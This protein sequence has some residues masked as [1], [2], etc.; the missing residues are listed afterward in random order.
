MQFGEVRLN[1]S[2]KFAQPLIRACV[3]LHRGG[4]LTD[5]LLPLTPSSIQSKVMNL[6]TAAT[7]VSSF[8]RVK[9][10]GPV[11]LAD[12]VTSEDSVYVY[13]I[14]IDNDGFKTEYRLVLGS[15]SVNL[16]IVSRTPL[17]CTVPS[18][19]LAH[20]HFGKVSSTIATGAAARCSQDE[21]A[22]I[23]DFFATLMNARWTRKK[24]KKAFRC[25]KM[26]RAVYAIACIDQAG[27]L[28]MDYMKSVVDI[29]TR[30]EEELSKAV[31]D[32]RHVENRLPRLWSP[33]Y[34]PNVDY[35]VYG[36]SGMTCGAP[37]PYIME[38]VKTYE[39]YYR[40]KHKRLVSSACP[41]YDAQRLWDLPSAVMPF[42][43]TSCI[44]Y[45]SAEAVPV[46]EGHTLINGLPAV[47]LPI[48]LMTEAP[49]SDA[50]LLLLSTFLPQTL[51]HYERIAKAQFFINH[52]SVHLPRLGAVLSKLQIHEVVTVLTAKACNQ[53]DDYEVLEWL[54]DAVLKMVQTDVIIKSAELKDWIANLHEGF[55]SQ[56]RSFLGCNKQLA[57][58]AKTLGIDRFIMTSALSREN[59]VPV[60]LELYSSASG[61]VPRCNA[62]GK[63]CADVIEALLG[64]AFVKEGYHVATEVAKELMCTIPWDPHASTDERLDQLDT[65]LCVATKVFTG[66]DFEPD[67]KLLKEAFTHPTL[68]NS[69]VASYQRLEWVG[70]A[71]GTLRLSRT[72][73]YCGSYGVTHMLPPFRLTV[74]ICVRNYLFERFEHT[75]DVGRMVELEAV[76]HRTTRVLSSCLGSTDSPLL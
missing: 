32:S 7:N 13:P 15:E 55:L 26:C 1:R 12:V 44:E 66:Y 5:R 36:P 17:V 24:S 2:N 21:L 34:D 31:Q 52:C 69:E 23:S 10:D 58:Y 57:I 73:S 35:I 71:V 72:D 39:D 50:G 27:G 38:G 4:L 28:M 59:W 3:R 19:A 67:S 22:L 37:F 65:A 42:D 61:V 11:A 41:L 49:M 64:L 53:P 75:R 76:S 40:I 45:K 43:E 25:S 63:T 8:Q 54:G 68:L 18:I 74:C 33:M 60:P 56:T 20:R 62:D 9:T 47:L 48:D 6:S 70:D 16:A 46:R 14:V 30:S 51:Y 29:T